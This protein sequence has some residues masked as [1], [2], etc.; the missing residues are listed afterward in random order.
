MAQKDQRNLEYELNC[1]KTCGAALGK[2]SAAAAVP[3]RSLCLT[4]AF[5][6][7]LDP[8]TLAVKCIRA[9]TCWGQEVTRRLCLQAACSGW[10]TG[11][12]EGCRALSLKVRTELPQGDPGLPTRPLLVLALLSFSASLLGVSVEHPVHKPHGQESASQARLSQSPTYA[13]RAD[14]R[15]HCHWTG[16]ARADSAL[17]AGLYF[18]N[19]GFNF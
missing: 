6:C 8:E 11:L 13:L 19:A 10:L 16:S 7:F 5:I 3:F 18:K 12:R 14:L 15:F 17:T 1:S 4:N 9:A 2:H